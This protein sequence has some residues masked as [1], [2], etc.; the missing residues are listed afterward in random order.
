MNG[1]LENARFTGFWTKVPGPVFSTP[2]YS[3]K[4][5]VKT[6][7][8]S[9]PNPLERATAFGLEWEHCNEATWKLYRRGG[10]LSRTP[11]VHGKWQGQ[12]RPEALAWVI[13]IAPGW[14]CVRWADKA[15]GP[16]S[17]SDARHAAE[18]LQIGCFEGEIHTVKNPIK[19]LN[20]WQSRYLDHPDTFPEKP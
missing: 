15:V 5:M 19:W 18:D 6:L 17:L 2:N 16:T 14:W 3:R 13:L 8:K 1:V 10:N 11:A 7:R 20:Y 9:R 12:D 4:T